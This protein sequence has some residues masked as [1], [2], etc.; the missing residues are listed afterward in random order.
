M[1]K[2]LALLAVLS[3]WSPNAMLAGRL[4]LGWRKRFA[5]AS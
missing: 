1:D 5:P 4:M 2:V 3:T